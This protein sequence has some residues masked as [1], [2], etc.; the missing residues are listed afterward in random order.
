[1]DP[2]VQLA[3][4]RQRR[5]E[6][7]ACPSPPSHLA[8][9]FLAVRLAV[10]RETRSLGRGTSR[11]TPNLWNLD[12][13]ALFCAFLLLGH[14]EAAIQVSLAEASPDVGSRSSSGP[15]YGAGAPD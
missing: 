6:E 1:V 2:L 7:A 14:M 5:T 8:S 15:S 12:I 4:E 13:D 11:L 10:G 3:E 9:Y